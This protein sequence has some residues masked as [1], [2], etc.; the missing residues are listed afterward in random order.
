MVISCSLLYDYPN[1]QERLIQTFLLLGG[2]AKDA[3]LAI[4]RD[5]GA[6]SKLRAEAAG[7]LG[8]LTPHE[9]VAV[10]ANT[11]S[12]HGFWAGR[13]SNS[14]SILEP[15][16]LAVS[17]RALGGLLASGNWNVSRLL[18]LRRVSKEGSAERELYDILL[19]WRYSPRIAMLENELQSQREEHEKDLRDLTKQLLLKQVQIR[20]MEQELEQL[21]QEHGQRSEEL[22]RVAEEKE[23]LRDRC[24]RQV[25]RSRSFT[26]I[27]SE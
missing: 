11:I 1:H 16:R 2:G 9:D 22:E 27:C 25:R 10:Y 6:Q 7:I 14:T 4:L 3:L 21:Q 23:A 19:G 24:R 8:M 20:E 18:D 15:E 26:T 5:P 13:A 12:G 17:L